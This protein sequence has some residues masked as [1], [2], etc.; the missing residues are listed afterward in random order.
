MLLKA[1]KEIEMEKNQVKS[2]E[3]SNVN[4]KYE[5]LNH[6]GILSQNT[7]G[8]NKEVNIVKWNDASPKI[9]IRD[10]DS[11]HKKMSRGISLNINEVRKLNE[12]FEELDLEEILM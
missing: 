11:E 12:L 3:N 2:N 7:T 10:W 4:F 5:I 6:I 8:W 1:K 9:D